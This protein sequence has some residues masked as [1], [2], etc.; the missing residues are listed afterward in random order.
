RR[1]ARDPSVRRRAMKAG[2]LVVLVAGCVGRVGEAPSAMDRRRPP[3]PVGGAGG[4]GGTAGPSLPPPA[5][6]ATGGRLRRLTSAELRNSVRDLLGDDVGQGELG[7]DSFR[8]GF[9]SIG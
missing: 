1:A 2:I 3:D 4:A 5:S 8:D 9:A 6:G 7:P